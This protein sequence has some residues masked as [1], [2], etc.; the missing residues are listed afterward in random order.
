MCWSIFFFKSIPD[1]I[2][3]VNWYKG[4]YC[5]LSYIYWYVYIYIYIYWLFE[6][7]VCFCSN[8]RTTL[9]STE[10]L[11]EIG[12]YPQTPTPPSHPTTKF[13]LHYVWPVPHMGC[14]LTRWRRYASVNWIDIGSGNGLSPVRRQAITWA[15]ALLLSIRP[16]GTIFCEIWIKIQN[17]HSWK[18]T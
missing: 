6:R 1:Y 7:W 4:E 5:S 10:L 14:S 16:M 18:C 17:F 3:S 13:T 12:K 8:Y 2:W 11:R 15:N 9:K